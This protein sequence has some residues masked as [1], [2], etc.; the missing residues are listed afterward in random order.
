MSYTSD[1]WDYSVGNR[2]GHYAVGDHGIDEGVRNNININSHGR[3]DL[4]LD[5]QFDGI[6]S[7][8]LISEHAEIQADSDDVEPEGIV[9]SDEREDLHVKG[10]TEYHEHDSSSRTVH[11]DFTGQRRYKNKRYV[12]LTLEMN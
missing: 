12:H 1:D 10:H 8:A 3:D 4:V 6:N 9:Y 2:N 11:R 5:G 7:H